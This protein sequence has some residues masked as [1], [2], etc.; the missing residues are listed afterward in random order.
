[1]ST[2]IFDRG[3]VK[4]LLLLTLAA[5]VSACGGGRL[6]GTRTDR[7]AETAGLASKTL[8]VAGHD[9]V[10]QGPP[11]FCIDESATESGYDTAFVLLGDCGVLAP[12]LQAPRPERRALLTAS[13]SGA[14]EGSAGVADSLISMDRFFRSETGRAALSRSSDAASVQILE[15]FQ[16]EGMFFLRASDTSQN[17]LPGLGSEYW[18]AYFDIDDRIVSVSVMSFNDAPLSPDDG[19]DTATDFAG[20]ILAANGGDAPVPIQVGPTEEVS[21][22]Q[23]HAPA[24]GTG[25]NR[26]PTRPTGGLRGVGLVRRLF[27]G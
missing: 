7:A 19:L 9:V 11:G 1:M 26:T 13:V 2:W 8:S 21:D 14:T 24:T 15:T 22:P 20:A 5:G 23:D 25:F 3:A 27:G 6:G 18:R 16:S 4:L 10:I 17:D 12:S